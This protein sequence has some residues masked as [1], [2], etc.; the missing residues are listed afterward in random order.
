M[1]TPALNIPFV[2]MFLESIKVLKSMPETDCYIIF[3]LIKVI[4]DK[5]ILPELNYLSV[6]AGVNKALHDRNYQSLQ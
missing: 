3:L 5:L 1:V 6:C 2:R 4:T